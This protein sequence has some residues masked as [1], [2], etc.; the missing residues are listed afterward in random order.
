QFA[1]GEYHFSLMV[2]GDD[3]DAVK[4]HR[5]NAQKILS[6]IDM[7]SAPISI[8]TDAAFFAQLPANWQYRP[9][10]AGLT[11]RNFA[12]FSPFH[13]FLIG[14]KDG[15]PWGQAVTRLKTLSGHPFFFNFHFTLPG[16]DNYGDEVAGNTRMIGM[17]GSGKTVTLGL[18]YCQAQKYAQNNPFSTVFFDKDRGAEVMIRALGGHYLRV[19]DGQPTGFSPFQMQSTKSNVAFLKKFVRLLIESPQY[20]I[21]P[22]DEDG[23]SKAVD[24]VMNSDNA[25][26]KRLS[27]VYQNMTSGTSKDEIQSSIK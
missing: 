22:L 23:I 5:S 8:A 21:T 27:G 3:R 10:V 17:T 14:K 19:K 9:R 16:E 12:S 1:M 20:P 26:L 2:M 24:T 18:L 25:S 13:N 7:L 6:D 15:N 11:S 4:R